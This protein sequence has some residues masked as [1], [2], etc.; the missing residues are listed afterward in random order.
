MEDSID[1]AVDA[2]H[3]QNPEAVVEIV[4]PH[5]ELQE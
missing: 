4:L 2:V 3:L 1:D 5:R